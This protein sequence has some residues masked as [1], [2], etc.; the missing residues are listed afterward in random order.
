MTE[1]PCTRDDCHGYIRVNGDCQYC[2]AHYDIG[3]CYSCDEHFHAD[4]MGYIDCI[5][6]EMHSIINATFPLATSDSP[7]SCAASAA[8][9]IDCAIA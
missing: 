9:T 5:S 6:C 4:D 1:L 8:A 7:L 3:F 2:S